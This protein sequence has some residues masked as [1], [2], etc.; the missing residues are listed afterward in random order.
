MQPF[1]N[2]CSLLTENVH[3]FITSDIAQVQRDL[4]ID[5]ITIPELNFHSD[6]FNLLTTNGNHQLNIPSAE[7]DRAFI[8]TE[9]T[10]T[11]VNM[12]WSLEQSVPFK[13]AIYS[14]PT[15]NSKYLQ[16]FSD[17]SAVKK[18]ARHSTTTQSRS[19]EW[20]KFY[21]HKLNLSL[22]SDYLLLFM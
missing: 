20:D 3:I 17:F 18:F 1:W 8:L 11:Y 19:T 15:A 7:D 10:H 13:R 12:E 22:F 9:F 21:N 5:S 6:Q 14:S 2:V 4:S 16:M